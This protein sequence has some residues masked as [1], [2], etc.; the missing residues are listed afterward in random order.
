MQAERA[1]H[2]LVAGVVVV[3]HDKRGVAFLSEPCEAHGGTARHGAAVVEHHEPERVAAEQEIGAPGPVVIGRRTHNPE[4]SGG[5]EWSPVGRGQGAGGVDV[6][7]PPFVIEGA[8]HKAA[9][10]RGRPAPAPAGYFGEA[11]TGHSSSR[12]HGIERGDPGRH[13]I[14]DGRGRYHDGSD[15]VSESGEQRLVG[16][17]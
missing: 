10:Q 15:L 16:Y 9:D 13:D 12:E 11:A 2:E 14:E 5:G 6:G 7:N 1:A 8:G 17:G 4:P 3:H